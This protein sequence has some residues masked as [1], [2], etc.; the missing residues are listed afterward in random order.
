M[1]KKTTKTAG[2]P[3]P[4]HVKDSFTEF[5]KRVG[6]LAKD[7]CA[8]AL[9]IWQFL[10]AHLR[11]RAK[12]DAKDHPL[13]DAT[14]AFWIELDLALEKIIERGLM[15]A[16]LQLH[17]TSPPASTASET[18]LAEKTLDAAGEIE[19]GSRAKRTGKAAKA[20]RPGKQRRRRRKTG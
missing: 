12:L 14:Q 10:P 8:G 11:E 4:D 6:T 2:W 3:V 15:T 18:H 9:F 7:D 16:L 5:C 17:D 19:A 13:D 20:P 1:T